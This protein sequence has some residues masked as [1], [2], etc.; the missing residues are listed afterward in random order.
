[1]RDQLSQLQ[2]LY[3]QVTHLEQLKTDMI[4]IASHDLLN[5]LGIANG[6][7]ELVR[8]DVYER[9]TEAERDY[10]EMIAR[11]LDRMQRITDDILSLERIQQLAHD[12]LKDD[13]E[14][15]ALAE[16]AV[17]A[18]RAQAAAKAQ[19]VALALAPLELRIRGDS[20]QIYEALVN[21][22]TNAI[23]Y[24]PEGGAISVAVTASEGH[25]L[26][27]VRDTGYGIPAD[28]QSRL[29]QPFFRARIDEA[30]SVDGVGLGLHL[31]RNIIE[32]HKGRMFFQSIYGQGSTFGFE[33]PLS[34]TV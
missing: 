10:V 1:M 26:I 25:G 12:P 32:R 23:K 2:V 11:Q 18:H 28:Q 30:Q 22:I 4:R 24:T 6:F 15:N 31:V 27:E 5:P 29:F 33:L 17:E 16:R 8:M 20:N 13:I 19:T 34:Q 9:M 3:E 21:L 7:V 14:L